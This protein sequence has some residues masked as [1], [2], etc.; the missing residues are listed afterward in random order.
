VKLKEKD[1]AVLFNKLQAQTL[2]TSDPKVAL[3]FASA[4]LWVLVVVVQAKVV[5]L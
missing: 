1:A 4:V 3:P 5:G 2:T